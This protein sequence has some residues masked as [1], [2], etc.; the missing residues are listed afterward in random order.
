[1]ELS[2]RHKS[3]ELGLIDGLGDMRTIMQSVSEKMLNSKFL[4]KGRLLI[5][6]WVIG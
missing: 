1:M 2:G 4:K 6:F 3:K 5:P